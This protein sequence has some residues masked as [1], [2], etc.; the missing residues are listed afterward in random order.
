MYN[1]LRSYR[2]IRTKR[3]SKYWGLKWVVWACAR[4]QENERQKSVAEFLWIESHFMHHTK[5]ALYTGALCAE[6]KEWKK[7]RHT[8]KQEYWNVRSFL[9]FSFRFVSQ[10]FLSAALR[11]DVV[12]VFFLASF[13]HYSSFSSLCVF[14]LILVFVLVHWLCIT[15]DMLR[16]KKCICSVDYSICSFSLLP[17]S[18]YIPTN[19][20]THTHSLMR[21]HAELDTLTNTYTIS[22]ISDQFFV[23][24]V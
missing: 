5:N 22:I 23:S 9:F 20:H 19:T 8:T 18:L 3:L 2:R 15:T 1:I 16:I 17:C 24:R 6:K 4:E 7:E 14:Q 13:F 12:V 10:F 21:P 11:F